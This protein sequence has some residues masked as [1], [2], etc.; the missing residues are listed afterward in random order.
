MSLTRS[1][2]AGLVLAAFVRAHASVCHPSIY[3]LN[4]PNQVTDAVQNWDNDQ[5]VN[6]LR[7]S[8][9]LT[10]DMWFAH[11]LKDFPPKDGDY[12]DI[13]SGG[14][15]V[16]EIC[17]NRAL[18]NSTRDPSTWD[19][20][21]Q[22]Y[23]ADGMAM[24]Q[25]NPLVPSPPPDPKWLG[26]TALAIAYTNDSA[27]LKPSDMVVF[28]ANYTSLFWHWQTYQ[29]PDKM[30]PC[31][32]FCLC[33]FNWIHLG[34]N[35]EGYPPEIYNTLFRCNVTGN[36]DPSN[37]IPLGSGKVPVLCDTDPDECVLT[38]KQPI[39]V[40]QAD[41]N[42]MP[43]PENDCDAP[44]YN[45]RYGFADGRQAVFPGQTVP[46]NSTSTSTGAGA[47]ASPVISTSVLPSHSVSKSVLPSNSVSNSILPSNSVS[48]SVQPTTDVS[49]S[50]LPTTD[51]SPS[52]LPSTDVSLSTDISPSA[53]LPTGGSVLLGGS[54]L[55]GGSVSIS[56]IHVPSASA[57]TNNTLLGGGSP[58]Q[59]VDIVNP[60]NS[61][62]VVSASASAKS[63]PKP[64]R[65][66]MRM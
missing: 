45:A 14:T 44:T 10:T 59:I 39:Y 27:N 53:V 15:L 46:V 63:C 20:P 64:K 55:P 17:D 47:S 43:D 8:D 12:L 7:K 29:I 23:G 4:W 66:R 1:A 60:T 65:S 25:M 56:N 38:A 36:T 11:G 16:T 5:F 3:G 13:P 50:A 49:P 41:G 22:L 35:G 40:W 9:N 48:K 42:N 24:H 61:G 32:G 6:P 52:A 62:S 33:T 19:Q 26:G 30:P 18:A 54:G 51:V 31:P 57:S 34:C 21:L 28:T 37:V 2:L 58:S